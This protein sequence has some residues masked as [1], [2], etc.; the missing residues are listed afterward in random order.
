MDRGGN[1]PHGTGWQVI[2]QSR[3]VLVL[4]RENLDMGGGGVDAAA[5]AAAAAIATAAAAP[6]QC[7]N[8]MS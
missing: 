1:P 6:A 5:V 3:H 4:F 7:I 2:Q 8:K